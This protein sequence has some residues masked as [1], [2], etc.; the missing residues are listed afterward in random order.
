[1][2]QVFASEV[3]LWPHRRFPLPAVQR[4]AGR[5][6]LIEVFFN[7]LDFHQVDTDLMDVG[8]S[9]REGGTEF[10]LSVTTLGARFG[11]LTNTRVLSRANGDRLAAMYRAVTEA[12]AADMD[13]DAQATYL[14]EGER[15]RSLMGWNETA[16]ERESG[17][18]HELFARHAAAEPDAVAVMSGDAEVSYAEL[19]ARAN[20]LAHYLRG[21]GVGRGDFVA[22]CARRGIE[23]LTGV[24]GVL[25]AGAAYLPLD[26]DQPAGR[27]G[28]M[29]TDSGASVLVTQE[30][31]LGAVPAP[32]SRVVCLDRDWAAVA[33]CPRH[34]PAVELSEDDLAYLIYTSGS[35]GLPKGVQVTHGGLANYL[36]WARGYYQLDGARGAPL[37]GSI[38]YDLTVPSFL[39]PLVSGRDVS[40]VAEDRGQAALISLLREPGDFSLVKITPA[41]LDLVCEEAAG[42]GVIGSVRAFVVGGE[43]MKPEMVA[44]WRRAAPLARIINEYGPTEA[45]VGCV[46]YEVPDTIDPSVPVP[47]GRPI[48]NTRAYVLDGQLQPVPVGVIGELYVGGAGVARGYLK[49]PELTAEMFLPDP[50]GR[51]P[52]ARMY[53]TGDLARRRP[54]GDLG[55]L[56]RGDDQVKI[57]GYRVEPGEIE[58]RLLLAPGVREAAVVARQDQPGDKRLVA[59][60]VQAGKD[61]APPQ[62]MPPAGGPGGRDAS[63]PQAS[64]AV[65]REFLGRTLPGYMVPATF[66]I[67]DA[68]PLGASGKVDR[69]ALPMPD[70][71]GPASGREHVAPRTDVE[72]LLAGIWADAL[73]VSRVGVHDGFFDL[74]GDS[75]MVLPMMAAARKAGLSIT[76]RTLYE[77]ETL[78]EL[79]EALTRGAAATAGEPAG[80][81][82]EVPLTPAL[83]RFLGQRGPDGYPAEQATLA[84]GPL[85]D[86]GAVDQALRA[87]VARHDAL[88]IR[89]APDGDHRRCWVAA[90]ETAALLRRVDLSVLAVGQRAAVMEQAAG[91]AYQSL[92]VERGPLLRAVLFQHG[93]GEPGQ[94]LVTVHQLAADA[95][96]WSVL[97]EDLGRACQPLSD[98]QATELPPVT[99]SF[100]RWAARLAR[101]AAAAELTGQAHHWLSRMPCRSLPADRQ[102]GANTSADAVTVT[103]TLPA[104]LT[105]VLA[106]LAPATRI[107]ELLLAALGL[108]IT[109]WTGDDRLLAEVEED[110]RDHFFDGVDLTA[111]VG[112]FAYRYP[113]ALWLPAK[114]EPKAVLRSVREQL[115]AVP[116]HGLGYELLLHQT[117][118]RELAGMLAELAPPQVLFRYAG[119]PPAERRPAGSPITLG[120]GRAATVRDPATPRA[121]L[122]EVG[123]AV[124]AGQLR[125]NWTYSTG[126]HDA[127]TVRWLLDDYLAEVTALLARPR[128]RGAGA[129]AR[130]AV[131]SPVAAMAE[132]SVPG[133]SVALIR[134][135]EIA[136]AGGYG[137]LAAG[138]SDPVTPQALFQSGSVSKFVTTLGALRLARDGLIDL[139]GDA[140]AYLT[141]WRIPVGD[142]SARVTV[143]QLL[144][145]L[146]GLTI[147][148][149]YESYQ[150]GE[151]LPSVLDVLRGRRLAKSPPAVIEGM[152]GA[153][154]IKNN[155]SYSAIQQLLADVTGEPF[156]ELMRALVF[157]PLGMTSSSYDQSFAETSGKPV[158][159]GHD[160][161]GKPLSRGWL[162]YPESGAAGLWTTATDLARAVAEVRR[163]H[164][165]KP[166]AVLTK[167]LAERMLTVVPP[168]RFYGM[169]S[170][171]DRSGADLEYGHT[172]QTTGYRAMMISQIY[173]GTGLVALTNGESGREVLKFL[174]TAVREYDTRFGQGQA[175]DTWERG[176]IDPSRA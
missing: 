7:Y 22:L 54:D 109:R 62:A 78:A 49:R 107:S 15:E 123:A 73:G 82:D 20:Q 113:V 77:N 131:P 9:V 23:L 140:N 162:V 147:P 40:V 72:K 163:A 52:G 106:A 8:S 18:A 89:V 36:L 48:A 39:L 30:R 28:F 17:C 121:H 86:P 161:S 108:V 41:H 129:A 4:L 160:A 59:Y 44:A 125:V 173:G 76:M 33:G 75:I 171:I 105:A 83:R 166:S 167:P 103:A 97:A 90:E 79:A 85:S 99:T 88:R 119:M 165:G 111:T 100:R 120:P 151:P 43:E 104:D 130:A 66:V 137:V 38:A 91:E 138:R 42:T 141:S 115:G 118:D 56:G 35:T 102:D 19:N 94:L 51:E 45:V 50:S 63:S 126:V 150:R 5:E 112:R 10:A 32:T 47:I 25:K 16:R 149:T 127:A 13:G 132:H 168:C 169:G 93:D 148:G 174:V 55:F 139:G 136:A 26:P 92:D 34:D 143:E 145:C 152:P 164:H 117:E 1:V 70:R 74:G 134:D 14:P 46:V 31:L 87:V 175:A 11:L 57:R 71:S 116:E 2:E 172:G 6:R 159:V 157:E 133:V 96:S 176:L 170:L 24:L 37:F 110:G 69:R 124:E 81:A 12:M 154:F 21:L 58:A 61:A 60:V 3:E 67:L 153:A 135:G 95:V 68:L 80:R 64:T 53:R 155:I 128:A 27:L 142:G 98:D 158:A 29:L 101:H 156:P 146:S 114:W 84:V 65:L 122:F 144:R